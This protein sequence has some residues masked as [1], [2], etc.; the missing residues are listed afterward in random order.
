MSSKR[1][2]TPEPIDI[3]PPDPKRPEVNVTVPADII[4]LGH[5]VENY[6]KNY[7]NNFIVENAELVNDVVKDKI[8]AVL[9]DLVTED[10][11]R[12]IYIGLFVGSIVTNVVM[13]FI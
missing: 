11:R 1:K 3:D 12:I 5:L 8:S 9:K 2:V 4:S 6:T 13:A 7:W 10:M